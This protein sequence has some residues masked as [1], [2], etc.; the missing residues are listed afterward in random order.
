MFRFFKDKNMFGFAAAA[1]TTAVV[2]AINYVCYKNTI[3]RAEVMKGRNPDA[4]I[5]WKDIHVS[6][7]IGWI[8]PY[9]INKSG[10]QG[11]EESQYRCS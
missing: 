10:A 4:E 8:S 9:V 6:G 5:G 2:A 11:E 7:T 1:S 3:Q